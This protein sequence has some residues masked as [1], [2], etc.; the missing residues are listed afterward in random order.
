MSVNL[1]SAIFET[2]FF[3]LKDEE[4]S[5]TKASTAKI[6]LLAMADH[7]NDEGEGSYPSV[8]RMCR[9]TALSEQTIRNTWK[10]LRYNGIIELHGASKWGTNNHTINTK[11]FPRAI[12]K[13]VQILELYPLDPPTGTLTPPNRS[14][15][16]S[17]PVIPEPLTILK[18]STEN[19]KTDEQPADYIIR[20]N[21]KMDALLEMANYPGAKIEARIESILSYLGE[22]FHRNTETSEW[23][24]FAKYIDSE[25][26]SKGWDV[27]IFVKWLF[28]QEGYKPE[29][30]PVKKMI[31][32]YP[33][34]FTGEVS[35]KKDYVEETKKKIESEDWRNRA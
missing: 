7:A 25:K 10:T 11:S 2:E 21:Q 13:E 1:M 12:G 34:A 16:S 32:F 17:L 4:G 9:K 14:S 33:S 23:R 3:D 26:K 27:E 5:V 28:T 19:L 31:E 15:E 20:A 18:T 24:K 29:F 8:E 35:H 6:V 30:W 22:T